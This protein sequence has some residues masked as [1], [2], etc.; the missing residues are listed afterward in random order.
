MC[1]TLERHTHNFT[2]SGLCEAR[3]SCSLYDSDVFMNFGSIVSSTSAALRKLVTNASQQ[4]I[5]VV[6]VTVVA[7]V[8][9]L[10]GFAI[11]SIW[12]CFCRIIRCCHHFHS[13][14]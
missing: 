2:G 6:I 11:F 4:F 12:Y 8:L 7:V 9:T 3:A 14:R 5:V 1:V 10:F 13:R